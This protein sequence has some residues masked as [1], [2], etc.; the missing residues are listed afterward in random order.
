M[1]AGSLG[2]SIA[3]LGNTATS[4]FQIVDPTDSSPEW[5]FFRASGS[6]AFTVT[7]KA[8]YPPIV[9]LWNPAQTQYADFTFDGTNTEI[10]A[11]TGNISL[12]PLTGGNVNVWATTGTPKLRVG[13]TNFAQSLDMWHDG[14]DSH[15]QPTSGRVIV[16]GGLV[17][18]SGYP[19]FNTATTATATTGTNGAPP[20]QVYGYIV[21][22]IGGVGVRIP[23][24]LP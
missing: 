16:D 2:G 19:E 17:I 23:Y 22:K 15:I 20:A 10:D 1:S 21:A 11:S 9:T 6:T 3:K 13:S 8:G 5:N 12:R 7:G 18:N 24:Y 4:G 14:T